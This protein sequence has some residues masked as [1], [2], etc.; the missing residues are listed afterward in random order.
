[1]HIQR[2]GTKEKALSEAQERRTAAS[3]RRAPT[4]STSSPAWRN[5][6]ARHCA[7]SAWRATLHLNLKAATYAALPTEGRPRS[8]HSDAGG[9]S[10]SPKTADSDR[11][12]SVKSLS[13]ATALRGRSLYFYRAAK[14]TGNS[15]F[16]AVER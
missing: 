10:G 9:P 13:L 8:S 1:M 16:P 2:K 7:Q 5:W 15:R 4:L 14:I 11:K 12:T 3:L 6:A